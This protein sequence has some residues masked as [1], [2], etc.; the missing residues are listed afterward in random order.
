MNGSI[1]LTPL[2]YILYECTAYVPQTVAL[3]ADPSVRHHSSPIVL[4]CLA[5]KRLATTGTS[6]PQ[7]M[8]LIACGALLVGG[9]DHH[10]EL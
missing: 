10:V 4:R 8:E 6:V 5:L 9:K 1:F 7:L 3:R 2:L